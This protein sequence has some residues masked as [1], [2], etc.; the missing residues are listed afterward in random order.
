MFP[1][2]ALSIVIVVLGDI[3]TVCTWDW[4]CVLSLA[5]RCHFCCVAKINS[6]DSRSPVNNVS[7]AY[8]W[9]SNKA[10]LRKQIKINENRNQVERF[11]FCEYHFAAVENASSISFGRLLTRSTHFNSMRKYKHNLLGAVRWKS[12]KIFSVDNCQLH[13][14]YRRRRRWRNSMLVHFKCWNVTS[15]IVD[16]LICRRIGFWRDAFN[17]KASLMFEQ[18]MWCRI[19]PL[20]VHLLCVEVKCQS[21]IETDTEIQFEFSGKNDRKHT[22]RWILNAEMENGRNMQ[23]MARRWIKRKWKGVR[24]LPFHVRTTAVVPVFVFAV[25]STTVSANWI[26]N[27]IGQTAKQATTQFWI[28][29][30]LF[31]TKQRQINSEITE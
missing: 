8:F 11:I 26:F 1:S 25:L 12:I 21:D 3:F 24:F 14:I 4:I 27:E 15:M 13:N 28:H 9:E 31:H 17:F 7:F 16:G 19:D 30:I 6:I 2:F 29:G 22:Q 18:K 20:F 10:F 5:L 23:T